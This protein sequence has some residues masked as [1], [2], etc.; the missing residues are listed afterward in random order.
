MG[1]NLDGVHVPGSERGTQVGMRE[2]HGA[3]EI[4]LREI[5]CGNNYAN[6]YKLGTLF[7]SRGHPLTIGVLFDDHS[8]PGLVR[9]RVSEARGALAANKGS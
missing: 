6:E 9:L 7:V 5:G 2:F 4:V 8:S 3:D 1:G